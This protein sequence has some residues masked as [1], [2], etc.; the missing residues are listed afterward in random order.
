MRLL[1]IKWI[2]N[3]VASLMV[4]PCVEHTADR[5]HPRFNENGL[6][7]HGENAV[8]FIEDRAKRFHVMKNVDSDYSIDAAVRERH[9]A[10]ITAEIQ[11]GMRVNVGRNEAR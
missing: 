3:R 5:G 4:K 8:K 1:G 9:V 7:T 10:S 6:S 11:P 2:G